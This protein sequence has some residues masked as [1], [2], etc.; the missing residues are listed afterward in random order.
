M[1]DEIKVR[2][3]AKK[4]LDQMTAEELRH[5]ALKW[6]QAEAKGEGRGDERAARATEVKAKVMGG[7]GK[8]NGKKAL[9]ARIQ[10]LEQRL[11]GGNQ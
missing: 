10:Q 9:L 4:D 3:Y 2:D 11:N 5:G 7:E 1:S 8:K 6:M